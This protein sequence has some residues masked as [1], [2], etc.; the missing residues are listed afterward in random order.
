MKNIKKAIVASAWL[1]V[2][3]LII[4]AVILTSKVTYNV[5]ENED[6]EGG[7]FMEVI[8]VG[9]VGSVFGE[10]E[11]ASFGEFRSEIK[12]I[13]KSLNEIK[14]ELYDQGLN[15]QASAYNFAAMGCNISPIIMIILLIVLIIVAVV[16]VAMIFVFLKNSKNPKFVAEAETS[17]ANMN[18]LKSCRFAAFI[19]LIFY[20]CYWLPA[21]LTNSALKKTLGGSTALEIGFY[22]EG[23]DL[24]VFAIVML[25]V[26]FVAS[27]VIEK[28]MSPKQ[29]TK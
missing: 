22:F 20:A 6:A 24:L 27:Y 21:V 16:A 23:L 7:S 10:I 19:P 13:G 1:C 2:Y 11:E 18:L 5:S 3:S 25:V 14:A 8:L 9:S 28:V 15:D 4:L 26:Y 17:G 12:D 29:E